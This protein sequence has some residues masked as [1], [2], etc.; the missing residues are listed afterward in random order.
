MRVSKDEARSYLKA[1]VESITSKSSGKM[2][3][4]PLCKSGTGP[5]KTGA[6]GI[7]DEGTRWKCQACGE[8]G[9]I[10]DL[11]GKMEN[12]GTF[13]EQANYIANWRGVSIGDAPA[14][15]ANEKPKKERKDYTEYFLK[16]AARIG[17]T[18]YHRGISLETLQRFNVGYDPAWK[19]ETSD[20]AW[21]SPRLII[22]TSNESYVA[23]NTKENI[24]ESQ[25]YIKTGTTHIFNAGALETATQPIYIVEGEIDALSIIDAGGE[26]IGLGSTSMVKQFCGIIRHPEQ[27]LVIAMDNDEAGKKAGDE[28]AKGLEAKGITF[29][30]RNPAGQYKDANER[31][32][33]DREGLRREIESLTAEITAKKDEEEA[34]ER[35]RYERNSTANYIDAFNR[36]VAASV[37]NPVYS[38]GF[39]ELDD[40]LDGGLYPGLYIIGAISSCGKT[41]FALQLAD[42]LAKQGHD[43]VYFTLEISRF[44]MIS[45]SISRHT[46]QY[47]LDKGGDMRNAKSARGITDGKRYTGYTDVYGREH[48]GYSDA[49][50]LTIKEATKAYAAYSNHIYQYERTSVIDPGTGKHTPIKM[51]VSYIDSVVQ[52]HIHFTGR[53]PIVF[54]DYMQLLDPNDPKATEKQNTDYVVSE[55]ARMTRDYDMCVIAISSFNRAA[56][57]NE[58][59]LA[60][61]KESGG[62]EYGADVALGMQLAGTGDKGF[63]EDAAKAAD[64]RNIEIKILKN[65]DAKTGQTMSFEY[66]AAF[67]MFIPKN[68][69]GVISWDDP[70]GRPGT[71][72]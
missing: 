16:A 40:M 24:P 66:R 50:K 49:E 65:R 59:G 55:L 62:I 52:D 42:T 20:K 18:D 72:D 26:A 46:A 33:A 5:H 41:A 6:F 48:P 32:Q 63:D 51:D 13:P 3:V 56:Y 14:P 69:G 71:R 58:P 8:G 9:D 29:Y 19:S 12:L 67:N 54:V 38:T 30:R 22:P 28:L 36:K 23:R 27:P 4:C 68:A 60:S 61:F 35:A 21:T 43:V 53:K 45:R 64:P 17:E 34:E 70:I 1:Y 44:K 39:M 57:K 7:Y 47:L 31:L 11:V 25:R 10:F 37:N 2:Y 15:A